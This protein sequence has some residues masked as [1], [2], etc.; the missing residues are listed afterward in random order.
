MRMATPPH[1]LKQWR[2]YR[3]L[4][5]DQVAGLL[6]AYAERPENAEKDIATTQATYQRVES[7]KHKYHQHMMEA[8]AE[9]YGTTVS[10]LINVN[11][12]EASNDAGMDAQNRDQSG[13]RLKNKEPVNFDGSVQKST[14]Q[15]IPITHNVP[16][17]GIVEAGAFREMYASG[18]PTAYIPLSVP[19]YRG[20]K[21]S[22]YEVAGDSMNEVFPEG[23]RVITAS[24]HDWPL[25]EG[26]YV[27]LRRHSHGLTE[28]SVKRLYVDD[29]GDWEFRPCS[30]NPAH[31]AIVAKPFDEFDQDGLEILAIVL[32]EAPKQVWKASRPVFFKARA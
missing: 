10:D 30:T 21:L 8:L 1:Y 11:P 16:V 26:N 17:L 15:S 7:G 2:K 3:G 32:F 20:I 24:P 4:T 6:E 29:G 9:V 13:N 18:E 28:T 25:H 12:A 27:I 23:T 14:L 19:E 22:A 5:Q 31:K